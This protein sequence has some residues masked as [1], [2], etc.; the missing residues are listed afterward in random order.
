MD[1]FAVL[2]DVGE[3]GGVGETQIVDQPTCKDDG[4][5]ELVF[6]PERLLSHSIAKSALQKSHRIDIITFHLR[7]MSQFPYQ[8]FATLSESKRLQ[9]QFRDHLSTRASSGRSREESQS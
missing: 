4:P 3:A 2:T 7:M 6:A 5:S 8:T 1:P 9:S